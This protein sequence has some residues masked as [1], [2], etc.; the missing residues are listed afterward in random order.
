MSSRPIKIAIVGGGAAGYFA[1]AAIKRNCE[2]VDVTVIYD[3]AT[4]HIGVGESIA[5]NGPGFMQQYL[6]LSNDF[7]WLK[8]SGSTFKLAAAWQGFDGTDNFYYSTTPVTGDS[9]VTERSLW[10]PLGDDTAITPPNDYSL[11][12]LWLHLTAKGLLKSDNPQKNFHEMFWFVHHDKS[13]IDK[14]GNWISRGHSYHINAETIKDVIHE[15]AGKPIGVK[16]LAIK[17]NGIELDF[18]GS[19]KCLCLD[20][21]ETLTADLYID[22][23]GFAKALIKHLPFEFEPCD[24]YFNNCAIVGPRSYTDHSRYTGRSLMAAMKWGW[25]FRVPMK[26]RSG[27]GYVFNS[28]MINSIDDLVAEYEEKTGNQDTI[29]RVIKWTPGYV[30]NAFVH[31]CIALGISQGFSEPFD[32]NGFTS[33]LRHIAKIVD[34]LK[35]DVQRTFDWKELYNKFVHNISQ[36]VI[37]RVHIAFHLALRNDTMYWQELKQAAQK[38]DTR[39]RL[40]EAIFDPKRK[41]LPGSNN[42]LPYSQ[43]VFVNQAIYSQVLIPKQ[44][45]ML[46][47]DEHKEKLAVEFFQHFDRV[48]QLKANSAPAITSFY[49]R[50]YP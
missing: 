5:W 8:K 33:T 25:R 28:N 9:R 31:N 15:Q 14:Y 50:L 32:A 17:I 1:A 11:Y 46:N 21:G 27:E 2:S 24:E 34:C 36:D 35:D 39:Q 38:F 44:Q 22:C 30:K 7:G 48:N 37:F 49:E 26:G 3:P 23:T 12:D 13:P 16:E 18:N 6:G 19:I 20:N 29:K 43:N 40:I 10:S 41:H 45:C 47:I 42:N 4:P